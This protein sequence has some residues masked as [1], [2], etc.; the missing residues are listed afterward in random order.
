VRKV[1]TSQDLNRLRFEKNRRADSNLISP[2]RI[3][4]GIVSTRFTISFLSIQ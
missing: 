1:V 4:A 3:E 2:Y